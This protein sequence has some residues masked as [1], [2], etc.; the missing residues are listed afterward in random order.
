MKILIDSYDTCC[1]ND[2]G[3][4]Q[5]RLKKIYGLLKEK[6]IDVKLFDKFQDKIDDFDIL[7]IFK[8]EYQKYPLIECAKT[9]GKKV[10]IST[11]MSTKQSWKTKLYNIISH[12]K[13]TSIYKLNNKTLNLADILICETPKEKDFLIKNHKIDSNKIFV[14]P[15]GAE[16][17]EYNG[18]EIYDIIHSKKKYVLQVGVFD[19]NKNQLNVIKALKNTNVELVL[20]G[21]AYFSSQ[22]Y[23]AKCVEEANGCDNIH[24]LGWVDHNSNLLKSAY[25]HADTLILPSFSETF[26]LV[27]IEGVMYGTKLALSNTI[28]LLSYD[29]FQ[30][31]NTFSPN[32][33]ED[34]RNVV[35]STIESKKNDRI[36]DRIKKNFS[37]DMVIDEHIKIYGRVLDEKAIDNTEE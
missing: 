20:I 12:F 26:G 3:G 37:W 1:Q 27:A 28:S 33:I 16:V 5:I 9:K 25:S 31:I 8:L 6:K 22:K 23:Y 24:F 21:G 14:I 36:Y 19:E 18:N 11:I 13:F 30:K 7:H 15:N 29:E 17:N 10:I 35:L 2:S 32:N 34:I 4:V